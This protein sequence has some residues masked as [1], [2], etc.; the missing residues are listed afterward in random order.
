MR[1]TLIVALMTMAFTLSLHAAKSTPQ[2]TA[3]NEFPGGKCF[4][5]RLTLTDKKGTPY[6]IKHPEKF[7]SQKAL[8]RRKRQGLKVDSTDL[9]INPAYLEGIEATGAKVMCKSKWNNTVLVKVMENFNVETL[10]AL[11][12]VADAF[13]VWTSPNELKRPSRVIYSKQ[14]EPREEA[15]DKIYGA[16]ALN[17]DMV[18]G[19]KLHEMG[20][21]GENITIA[22][23]DGGFMNADSLPAL[24][25]IKLL[26][27][28]DFVAF[29]AESIFCELDH[30]TKVLST[31]ALDVK[32]TFVGTAPDAMFWLIRTEDDATETQA[33]EDYWAAAAEFADSVGVDIITSSLGYQD[34]DDKT[35]DHKYMELDG[36]H[37]IISR[38]ASRLASKGIIHVNSAG[39]DGTAQW[40]KINF[41]A[42]ARDILAV[43]ALKP[44]KTNASFSSLGPSQDG[45]VKPDIMSLG[46][47]AAVMSGRG[48]L[49]NDMGTSFAAPIIA[50]MVASLW[51]SAPKA[52]AYEVMDAIRRSADSYEY[53]NNVFGYGIPDFEKAYYILKGN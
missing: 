43:G 30:G 14:L 46:S 20:Y 11:P 47:P 28:K 27:T 3:N 7:L 50:G 17:I 12:Y 22:V 32:G 41:P 1:K 16:S 33:E 31:I 52:T 8:E 23:F 2:I 15:T 19:R 25:G 5:Y 45:R 26:G 13:K 48:K 53:P 38:T 36:N 51:Q 18:N 49:S 21:R 34:F 40:H 4:L 6:S 39:N 29:P 10:T 37:A 42:D 24:R 44:D 9:P 35:T